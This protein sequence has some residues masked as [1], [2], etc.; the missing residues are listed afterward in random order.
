MGSY[1]WRNYEITFSENDKFRYELYEVYLK[2]EKAA[3]DSYKTKCD[4]VIHRSTGYQISLVTGMIESAF[5]VLD[6]QKEQLYK[7]LQGV[8]CDISLVAYS[9]VWNRNSDTISTPLYEL[10]GVG[11]KYYDLFM[12]THEAEQEYR[13]SQTMYRP[14]WVGGGFGISGAIKG[15][16]QAEILNIATGTVYSAAS[17]IGDMVSSFKESR[18]LFKMLSIIQE[19]AADIIDNALINI[20]NDILLYRSSK[21]FSI[22]RMGKENIAF[23]DKYRNNTGEKAAK[24]LFYNLRVNPYLV[25]QYEILLRNFGDKTCVFEQIGAEFN[26]DIKHIKDQIMTE[27]FKKASTNKTIDA[28][29]EYCKNLKKLKRRLGIS[30]VYPREEFEALWESIIKDEYAYYSHNYARDIDKIGEIR[31]K[32]HRIYNEYHMG[33]G[34][35]YYVDLDWKL[36]EEQRI[37]EQTSIS[38]DPFSVTKATQVPVVNVAPD[39]PIVE[40]PEPIEGSPTW[41][42]REVCKKNSLNEGTFVV[43]SSLLSNSH[44]SQA[45][46]K[47]EFKDYED[48]FMLYSHSIIHNY[49]AGIAICSGGVHIKEKKKTV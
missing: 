42:A 18:K 16:I 15:I 10:Y 39:Q 43:S 21:D 33:I 23:I 7:D 29:D 41:I 47:F 12:G 5:Q 36:L 44:Y 4:K 20:Y 40:I 9:A 34:T 1:Q 49:E 31:D 17:A 46:D 30:K 32:I 28:M 22:R 45:K 38:P 37:R 35:M 25:D 2:N 26:I 3:I 11:L 8:G 6:D 27:Y 19:T 14:Q 24:E 13:K 48:V